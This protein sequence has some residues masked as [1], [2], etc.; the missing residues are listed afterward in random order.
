MTGLLTK[1]SDVL[2]RAEE[3]VVEFPTKAGV[4]QAVSGVSFQVAPGQTLGIVGESG[5]GKSTTGRALLR[6]SDFTSGSVQFLG[7]KLEQAGHRRMRELRRSMQMIFQ[8]PLGSLNPRRKVR[9]IV[10][11]GLRVAGAGDDECARVAR[12]VLD[13]VGLPIDRFGDVRPRALSGGQ[14]QR[15]A[16]ARAI[17][18]RPT[19]LICDEPVSALDVSVQAQI[20]NLIEDLK[21]EYAFTVLFISHDLGVVRSVS[22]QI[23]VMYLGKVVE[24]G[25]PEQVY[26]APA[27]PYTRALLDSVPD[28]TAEEGFAGPALKG[29]IPSPLS[30]PSGC[31]FRTRCP[32]AADLCREQEPTPRTWGAGRQV[33]CH[34]PLDSPGQ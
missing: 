18:V 2:L 31:R 28:A 6:L 34:F 1:D 16:I 26:S 7:E 5:C 3:L 14:A 11:E 17:A 20:L 33:A 15:V 23:M 29:D 24:I 8:D 12:E 30:P 9:D 19:L 32:R 21:Q 13:Q 25:D 10:V 4:L 27:H 22:D